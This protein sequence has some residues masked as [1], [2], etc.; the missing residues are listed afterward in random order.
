MKNLIELRKKLTA[1]K[2]EMRSFIALAQTE[3]RGFTDEEEQ[4]YTA[5]E[6][7]QRSLEDEIKIEERSQALA[8]STGGQQ[9][10]PDDPN[11]EGEFRDF[12]DLFTTYRTNPTDPRLKEYR[13]LAV[14]ASITGG[15]FV[16]PQYSTQMLEIATQEAVVRPRAMVIPADSTSPDASITLPALDQGE[17]SNMYGGVEVH[18]I[19]EGDEKPET[20]AKFRDITLT[21]HEVAAHITVTDKLLRNAPTVNAVINRLFGGAI[22]AA[23]DYAFLFGDGKAKPTGAITSNAATVVARKTAKVVT[24]LDIVGMLAKA[25]LGGSLVWTASQSILPQLLTMKDDSGALIYQPNAVVAVG[26]TLLGYPI[27]FT[28]NSPIL[29]AVGDLTLTD[30]GYY[31]IKDGAGIFIEASNAPL[32]TQNKTIVKAFWNVD[33]KPWVTGPFKLENGYEV[34]PFVKLSNPTV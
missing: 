20:N 14:G 19:G 16:P 29:G 18:W 25:K 23:E 10:T 22:A 3:K 27:K 34:S 31:V 11:H 13:E 6:A 9:R 24:Y 2:E 1:K 4:K 32:F 5:L 30:L 7:E 15:I 21:P 26:G 12:G 33:G 8:M 17:G 28:E